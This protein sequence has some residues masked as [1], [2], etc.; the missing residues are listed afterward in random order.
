MHDQSLQ[1]FQRKNH[2]IKNS[3]LLNNLKSFIERSMN[4]LKHL[5]F[6]MLLIFLD[7]VVAPAR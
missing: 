2:I 7:Y 5:R 4:K 1:C 3:L 6:F